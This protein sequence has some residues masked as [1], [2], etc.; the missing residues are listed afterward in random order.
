MKKVYSHILSYFL[1]ENAAALEKKNTK[2]K[3]ASET[4]HVSLNYIQLWLKDT[5][6]FDSCQS[7]LRNPQCHDER[8]NIQT[9][10]ILLKNKQPRTKNFVIY[11]AYN[12]YRTSKTKT[13]T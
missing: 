3:I 10:L 7:N 2:E 11:Y 1:G 13:L 8:Y 5:K 9:L 4:Y 6:S 12:I